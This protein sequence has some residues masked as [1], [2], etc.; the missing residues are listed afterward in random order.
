M[1]RSLPAAL[2]EAWATL[3]NSGAG[4]W[5]INPDCIVLFMPERTDGAV[6]REQLPRRTPA[7]QEQRTLNWGLQRLDPHQV[8]TALRGGARVEPLQVGILASRG[9]R[10]QET[11]ETVRSGVADCLALIA[12]PEVDFAAPGYWARPPLVLAATNDMLDLWTEH[13][14]L[15]IVD[16]KGRTALHHAV[17]LGLL[18]A[19]RQLLE[20][21][22]NTELADHN[23]YTPLLL[24]LAEGRADHARLLLDR[25]A[26]T[27]QETAAGLGPLLLVQRLDEPER[28][29]LTSLLEA[30]GAALGHQPTTEIPPVQLVSAA[31][32][33]REGAWEV[34]GDWLL[35][36]GDPRGHALYLAANGHH[37]QASAVLGDHWIQALAAVHPL[38]EPMLLRPSG[39]SI[40][41]RC[42]F[43]VGIE[44]RDGAESL[45]E[46]VRAL[47]A[48]PY[49]PL[50]R[51]AELHRPWTTLVDHLPQLHQLHL[52]DVES[53][54]MLQGM[55]ARLRALR[56]LTL[57]GPDITDLIVEHEV[58]EHIHV[59]LPFRREPCPWP[60]RR[61]VTPK[62]RH[63]GV[64]LAG[65]CDLDEGLIR[66]LPPTMT[67][68]SL[69][70]AT[71]ATVQAL[72]QTGRLAALQHLRLDS[73]WEPTMQ[74]VL[75]NA[76]A[77]AHLQ[78][79]MSMLGTSRE[80]RLA[81][82]AMVRQALPEVSLRG[83]DYR[84]EG[85]Y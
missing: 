61:L 66:G 29:R 63:L 5:A 7:L 62:L 52:F 73:V 19:V 24:A 30:R 84:R 6:T 34:L 37:D 21:G 31:A 16:D 33:D 42:G 67:S 41:H 43:P 60:L 38:L 57:F 12:S 28:S 46:P 76:G 23:G 22:A 3:W 70:P 36:R 58:V 79:S 81:L 74:Y 85:Q 45:G 20:H 68:L 72:H 82:Y 39:V 1:Y 4:L 47:L 26:G 17:R 71:L 55:L 2:G 44:A 40:P 54:Q 51:R 35:Q 50:I 13:V 14:S 53:G 69:R 8:R 65:G 27:H 49:A 77:F 25:G 78:L 48:S 64:T 9:V 80:E 59:G 83:I 15:D 10:Y 11:R 56:Q 75:D 32:E 18:P